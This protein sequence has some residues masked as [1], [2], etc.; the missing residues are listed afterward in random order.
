MKHWKLT[1]TIMVLL[2]A[3]SQLAYP[4]KIKL[5]PEK[6]KLLK[7]LKQTASKKESDKTTLHLAVKKNELNICRYLLEVEGVDVNARINQNKSGDT[8]RV[9]KLF[10]FLGGHVTSTCPPCVEISGLWAPA[11]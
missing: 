6:Q 2:L 10:S 5:T 8:I 11:F 3:L 4:K 7:D 1:T 9:F